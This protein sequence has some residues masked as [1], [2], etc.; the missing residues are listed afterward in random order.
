MLKTFSQRP[1]DHITGLKSVA[2]C[3]FHGDK[4]SRKLTFCKLYLIPVQPFVYSRGY[5]AALRAS[6]RQALQGLFI[7]F[8]SCFS[9]A[10]VR[11]ASEWNN[12]Y[13]SNGSDEENERPPVRFRTGIITVLNRE[14]PDTTFRSTLTKQKTKNEVNR[15]WIWENNR[16]CAFRQGH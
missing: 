11:M 7:S 9:K 2:S 5:N 1:P 15:D 4:A 14:K 16:N 13:I 6:R 12:D 8:H 3:C 10:L